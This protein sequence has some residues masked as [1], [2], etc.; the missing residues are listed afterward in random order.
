MLV[1]G[2][3]LFL[4]YQPQLS[5]P[6]ELPRMGTSAA[7]QLHQEGAAAWGHGVIVSSGRM[8]T[9]VFPVGFVA[10]AFCTGTVPGS[11]E[12]CWELDKKTTSN[13]LKRCLGESVV[14]NGFK[15]QSI[16]AGLHGC[17]CS[18][19]QQQHVIRNR[20]SN[21][22]VANSGIN[23]HRIRGTGIYIYILPTC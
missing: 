17:R 22:H 13:T 15:I 19:F 12:D 7:K 16:L 5:T 1:S 6:V 23:A 21:N 18:T 4:S 14:L 11:D 9:A 20:D 8:K 10:C 2:R 3:V